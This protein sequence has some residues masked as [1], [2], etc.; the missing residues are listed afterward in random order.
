M[1][2]KEHISKLVS[3]FML[4]MTLFD[5]D[6][7]LQIF[8]LATSAVP[9]LASCRVETGYLVR[10]GRLEPLPQHG[11]D[12]AAA[13]LGARLAK[14]SGGERR[15]TVAGRNWAH[16]FPLG[17]LL[18]HYGY[19]V[20]SA[21]AEPPANEQFL[22][23][24]LAQQAGAALARAALYRRQADHTTELLEFNEK[25]EHTNRQLA[26]TVAD[27]EQQSRIHEMLTGVSARGDGE[28][29]IAEAVHQLTG[30]PVAVED[31]FGNLRAWAGSDQPRPY[32]VPRPRNRAQVL[33]EVQR[34]GRALHI[35]ERLIALAQP[36][37]E[38]LGVLALV[39]PAGT[40]DRH[41]V[42]ALEHGAVV[43]AMELAH[44]RSLVEVELRLRRDLVDDLLTGTDD[45][46]AFAR[47]GALGVDLRCQHRV[48]VIQSDDG[49]NAGD[50]ARAV[51]QAARTIEL[52]F[53]YAKQSGNLVMI[54]HGPNRTAELSHWHRLHRVVVTALKSPVAIG[55]GGVCMAPTEI[56][57]SW[58]EARRALAI[59]HGSHQPDGVT[60]FDDVGIYGILAD[61]G[62]PE[63][64]AFVREWL[65]PLLDYDE[66][67]HT[68]LVMTL[69]RYFESGGNYDQTAKALLI[70]RSTLRY[71]LQRIRNL[72]DRDLNDVDSRLNLHI[73][74]R[75]WQMQQ[76]LS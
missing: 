70:H 71:R 21:D 64:S 3:L 48:S 46:S 26:G 50:V 5:Q 2:S 9:S 4:S 13:A 35:G 66:R 10:E 40:A 18:G 31:R 53:L 45:A 36:R 28:H 17:N 65:G 23:K 51:H 27:L 58:E 1:D 63:V 34:H 20:V 74:T 29:T 68:V 49:I 6:D 52:G 56:P 22:V 42:L 41:A 32:P 72:I 37:D 59:R 69:A 12:E 67:H 19:L 75:A 57:R 33:G 60:A 16:A 11:G 62:R 15:V 55:V 24:I 43:L 44:Q 47:A 25:L 38:V 73:A 8:R 39:D 76:G 30:L 14:L 61:Q 7:D 54:A